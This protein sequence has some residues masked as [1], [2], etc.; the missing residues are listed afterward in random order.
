MSPRPPPRH[1]PL[2]HVVPPR[3]AGTTG[4][5]GGESTVETALRVAVP[6]SRG[7]IINVHGRLQKTLGGGPLTSHVPRENAGLRLALAARDGLG[8]PARAP[9][10]RV[11][12][13]R[14]SGVPNTRRV[15][16]FGP[17]ERTRA[18][19]LGDGA[20]VRERVEAVP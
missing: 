11:P 7:A 14:T 16:H 20:V 4:G 13:G 2:C 3:G 6:V 1:G 9:A 18:S 19:C 8:W 12:E 5:V 15:A 17:A 10:R